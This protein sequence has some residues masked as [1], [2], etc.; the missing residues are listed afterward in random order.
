MI[1]GSTAPSLP[2][3]LPFYFRVRA[4]SLQRARLS[5]SL[6]QAIRQ[7]TWRLALLSLSPHYKF[8]QENFIRITFFATK[9]MKNFHFLHLTKKFLPCEQWF[10][11][12]GRYGAK[13]KKTLRATLRFAIKDARPRDAYVKTSNGVTSSHFA[14][15]IWD[16]HIQRQDRID[17]V[18]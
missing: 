16:L 7:D 10:L 6:E 18:N 4:F 2:S 17:N 8:R 9:A 3:F 12:V 13:G 1:A 14:G 5:R 11:A 15:K